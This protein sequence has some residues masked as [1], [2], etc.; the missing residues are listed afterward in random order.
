MFARLAVGACGCGCG[1]EAVGV[2]VV[3]GEGRRGYW[4]R[5]A[6]DAAARAGFEADVPI[7]YVRYGYVCCSCL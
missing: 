3:E 2:L 4:R 6:A 1:G 7:V 5:E